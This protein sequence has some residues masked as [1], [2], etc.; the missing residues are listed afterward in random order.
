MT[1]K[2]ADDEFLKTLQKGVE[3]VLADK[4]ATPDEKIKALV[5]GTKILQTK[6]KIKD[7]GD[8]DETGNFFKR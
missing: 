5:A 6:H 8:D 3:S 1:K 4:D 7:K 2:S